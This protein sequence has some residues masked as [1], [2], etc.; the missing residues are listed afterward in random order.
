MTYNIREALET[1]LEFVGLHTGNGAP[2]NTEVITDPEKV[3]E[4]IETA[5]EANPFRS[6]VHLAQGD[7]EEIEPTDAH[8][9]VEYAKAPAGMMVFT[10]TVPASPYHDQP[11]PRL[12]GFLVDELGMTE[13]K[14]DNT[15]VTHREPDAEEVGKDC[16]CYMDC[17]RDSLSGRF[18]QHQGEPCEAHPEAPTA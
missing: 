18:H 2:G 5:L 11:G 4:I 7:R 16:S 9:E 13:P 15:P 3:R 8:F 12:W 17:H 1:T 6:A 10:V 14:I